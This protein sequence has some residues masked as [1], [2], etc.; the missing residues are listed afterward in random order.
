MIYADLHVHT[1]HSD[2]VCEIKDVLENAFRNG[3]KTIAITDHDT[4][5]HYDEIYREG[6]RLGL[7]IVKGVEMSCYDFDVY[8][9]VHVVGLWLNEKRPT[10]TSCVITLSTVVISF[11]EN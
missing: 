6:E 9:K 10:L 8:K 1:N 2:G 5:N 11:T 3:I 4:T 7:N